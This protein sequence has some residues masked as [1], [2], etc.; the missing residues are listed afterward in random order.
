[1]ISLLNLPA[2]VHVILGT[3]ILFSIV[4][5]IV[6]LMKTSI[7]N[8]VLLKTFSVISFITGLLSVLVGDI[9]YIGYRRPEGARI[10][11]KEGPVPWVHTI[12]M[13]FK[14][15]VA[16]FIPVILFIA[17]FLIFYYREEIFEKKE[18][19]RIVAALYMIA[20]ILI[21]VIFLLGVYITSVQPL[22]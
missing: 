18:L 9:A 2:H 21:L 8:L 13:E 19:R 15:H 10:L 14:E 5:S 22:I 17:L 12:G 1:M 16:H 4:G 20:L 11:I 7:K 6:S 3:L